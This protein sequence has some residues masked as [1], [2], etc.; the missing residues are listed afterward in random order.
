MSELSGTAQGAVEAAAA[1]GAEQA[2]AYASHEEN[3]EVRVHGGEVESLTAAAQTGLGVRAWIGARVGYAYGTDLS[4]AGVGEIA[5]RAAAAARAAD[6]DEFAAPPEPAAI[7]GLA[8]ISDPSL[9]SWGTDRA[10]ELA[11]AVE[12]A[13]LA[14][15][16]RVVGVEQAVYADAAERVAIASGSRSE[17]PRP[18][19]KPRPVSRAPSPSASACR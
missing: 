8:G 15:D 13:A 5:A 2:E 1:A 10:V 7:E 17:G 11:L 9:S 4:A 14:A 19:P 3:R 12:R 18:R 6:E 16:P